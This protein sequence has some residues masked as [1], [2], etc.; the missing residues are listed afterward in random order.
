MVGRRSIGG[1]R[2]TLAPSSP[3]PSPSERFLAE[4]GAGGVEPARLLAAR[5]VPRELTTDVDRALV[6]DLKL[7]LFRAWK[8]E[9][10]PCWARSDANLT[11]PPFSARRTLTAVLKVQGLP[12][13]SHY[14]QGKVR[15]EAGSRWVTLP[16]GIDLAIA[17]YFLLSSISMMTCEMRMVDAEGG[18]ADIAAHD[19]FPG[20]VE[21]VPFDGDPDAYL[22]HAEAALRWPLT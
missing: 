22:R 12:A 14:S 11:W 5:P 1:A 8:R 10:P 4:R 16:G 6:A 18:R 3:S 2:R 20:V 13:V 7:E 9:H 17:F 21:F 19:L 15:I